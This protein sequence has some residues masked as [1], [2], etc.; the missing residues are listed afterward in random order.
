[1]KRNMTIRETLAWIVLA[2]AVFLFS[3]TIVFAQEINQSKKNTTT[4]KIVKKEDGKTTRIDTTFDSSDEEAVE[5]ILKNLGVEHGMSFNFSIP[6]PPPAPGEEERIMKFNY[7][8]MSDKDREQLKEEMKGVHEKMKE[9]HIEM[10][11]GKDG[12]DGDGYSYNFSMPPVPPMNVE[13]FNFSDNDC[14]EKVRHHKFI[15]HHLDSLSDADHVVIMGDEDEQPPVFEKEIT[16]KHGEKVFVYK[17]SIPEKEKSQVESANK[18][19]IN[20]YPNPNDGKFSIRFHADKKAELHIKIYN[21]QGKEVYSE[22]LKDFSGDYSNQFDLS[23]KGKG[24]YIIKISQGT[25]TMTE[26]FVIE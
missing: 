19:E 22:T 3:V 15:F 4:I 14:K 8:D 20:L 6:E 11:S 7:K 23:G 17:R 16:G 13:D 10:R 26:K 25:K 2:G 5:N 18:S 12:K 21:A 9:I 1:M 24:N